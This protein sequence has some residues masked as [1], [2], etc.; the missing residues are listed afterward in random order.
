MLSL[1]DTNPN[2]NTNAL[3]IMDTKSGSQPC[4]QKGPDQKCDNGLSIS[5]FIK[6]N[7]PTTG[8]LVMETVPPNGESQGI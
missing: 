5:A 2:M 8:S 3:G 4:F 7:N 6:R 1:Y